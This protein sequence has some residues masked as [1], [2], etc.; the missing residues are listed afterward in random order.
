VK[1]HGIDPKA[2]TSNVLTLI[3]CS[4]E[5]S[6]YPFDMWMKEATA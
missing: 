1:D 4:S 2:R 3:A 6:L 5:S